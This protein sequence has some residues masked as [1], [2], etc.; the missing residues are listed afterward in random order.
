MYKV[1]DFAG[2]KVKYRFIN[3]S[4]LYFGFELL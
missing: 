2:N 1:M 3:L 4:V